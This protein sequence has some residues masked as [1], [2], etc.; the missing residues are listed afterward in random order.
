MV[1]QKPHYPKFEG[2]YPAASDTGRQKTVKKDIEK[3]IFLNSDK[4]KHFILF[5]E[6][7]ML[8]SEKMRA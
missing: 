8:V 2:L 5:L 1:E 4:N 6:C 7:F 3:F